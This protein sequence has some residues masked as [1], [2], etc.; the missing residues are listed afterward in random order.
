MWRVVCM[1][2]SLFYVCGMVLL[3]G[4]AADVQ[5][6]LDVSLSCRQ[7]DNIGP[8]SAHE[9]LPCNSHDAAVA[10]PLHLRVAVHFVL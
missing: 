6:L 9:S 3:A 5:C 1:Y 10:L 7:G 4:G 8:Q 2:T